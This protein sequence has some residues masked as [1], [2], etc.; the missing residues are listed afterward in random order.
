MRHVLSRGLTAG[1]HVAFPGTFH[2][3]LQDEEGP[4]TLRF[5]AGVS[6][7]GSLTWERQLWALRFGGGSLQPCACPHGPPTQAYPPSAGQGPE[8]PAFVR[9]VAGPEWSRPSCGLSLF[10]DSCG[11]GYNQ[12]ST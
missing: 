4:G 8:A 11:L 12:A 2:G 3:F 1:R 6:A 7:E 5:E 10:G 9:H